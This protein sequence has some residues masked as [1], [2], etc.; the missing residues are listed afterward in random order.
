MNQ[1]EIY[2]LKRRRKG[3]NQAYL[4]QQLNCS[5]SLISRFE[6]DLCTMASNKIKRYKEIIDN[7]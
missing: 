5:Q 1:K 4:S 3:I 7:H 2:L 6:K